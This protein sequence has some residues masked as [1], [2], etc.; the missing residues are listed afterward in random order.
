MAGLLALVAN[1][2]AASV[3]LGAIPAEVAV[4]ATVVAFGAVG[5]IARHVA[6]A[7]TAVALLLLAAIATT[8]ALV[9][10]LVATAAAAAV[11]AVTAGL[12]AVAGDVTDLSTLVALNLSAAG[13][14][15]SRSTSLGAVTR[16]VA[17]LVASVAGLRVLRTVRAV[18]AHVALIS[19]VVAL[20]WAPV[21]AVAGLMVSGTAGVACASAEIHFCRIC[22]VLCC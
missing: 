16:D 4:L 2:L 7:T 17:G 8:T 5:T 21:W 18:T 1:L 22:V 12:H 10:R 15:T 6:V 14:A 20:G 11:G 3:L 19:T 13:R 9:V